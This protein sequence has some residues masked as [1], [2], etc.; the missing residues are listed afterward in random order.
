MFDFR[1]RNSII[2]ILEKYKVKLKT[3]R[4]NRHSKFITNPLISHSMC[5]C[6]LAITKETLSFT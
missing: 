4:N 5:E 6:P 1:I 3:M 2:I